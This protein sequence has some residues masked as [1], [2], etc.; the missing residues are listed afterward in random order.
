M[1]R[2]HAEF[3]NAY[4]SV[5]RARHALVHFARYAGLSGVALQDFETAMGEALANA[6]EYG[7]PSFTVSARLTNGVLNVELADGGKG[8]QGWSETERARP[9]SGAPRGFGIFLMRA[10]MD[11]VEYSE[12]GS[13]LRLSKT[14]PFA[15]SECSCDED[16]CEA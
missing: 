11:R 8:F 15:T 16:C 2:Y 5:G 13:R 3:S 6:V 12:G 4:E 10:L 9:P 14:V 7:G 1:P